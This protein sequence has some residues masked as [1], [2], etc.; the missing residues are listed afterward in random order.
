MPK[1]RVG[2]QIWARSRPGTTAGHNFLLYDRMTSYERFGQFYDAEM[3]DRGAAAEQV[4][5]LIRAA[6]PDAKKVLELGCGTDQ[7]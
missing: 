5:K 7:S 1:T 2:L 3:G 4:M 6:K